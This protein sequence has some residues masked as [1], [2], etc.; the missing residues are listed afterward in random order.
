M[1]LLTASEEEALG[2]SIRSGDL[3][4]RNELVA[5]NRPYVLSR[6]RYYLARCRSASRDDLIQA[7]C[8]GLIEAANVFDPQAHAGKRFISIAKHYVHKE[9]T[10]YLYSR[11]VV[12]IPHY[13]KPAKRT[14]P[15]DEI[16]KQS[17]AWAMQCAAR[18]LDSMHSLDETEESAG[19][20]VDD[21]DLYAEIHLAIASKLTPLE[22]DVIRRR[23]GLGCAAQSCRSLAK[24]FQLSHPK[25]STIERRAMDK[26][27]RQLCATP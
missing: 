23:F 1:P 7:G 25:I 12:R 22:A 3:A 27:R 19:D 10:Q 18:A 2:R 26:L 13:M 16:R 17:S 20:K 5:R 8:I 11:N 21:T 24:I 14:Q 9:M 6:A 15:T 4:A